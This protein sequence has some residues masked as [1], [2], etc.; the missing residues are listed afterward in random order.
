MKKSP[1]FVVWCLAFLVA[2]C[3]ERP[4]S[5]NLVSDRTNLLSFLSVSCDVSGEFGGQK[6]LILRIRNTSERRLDDVSISFNHSYT[7]PLQ[8]LRQYLGF[9]KGAPP[10]GRSSILPDD[11][12]T[13]VFSHDISNHQNMINAAKETLPTT[14]VPTSISIQAEGRAGR[15]ETRSKEP[16]KPDA[17]D[18]S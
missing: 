7:A 13:F 1:F 12:L 18:D 8:N 3:G 17:G 11:D 16:D 2:G 14:F 5:L 6:A 4:R 15:W 9:W 10:L